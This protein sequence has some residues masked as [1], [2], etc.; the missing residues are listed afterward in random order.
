[1][2]KIIIIFKL[3]FIAI[4]VSVIISSLSYTALFLLKDKIYEVYRQKGI[5]FAFIAIAPLYVGSGLLIEL[6]YKTILPKVLLVE[7]NLDTSDTIFIYLSS[8]IIVIGTLMYAFFGRA[9][10]I[11]SK[12]KLILYLL[13]SILLTSILAYNQ[14]F[15]TLKITYVLEITAFS[16]MSSFIIKELHQNKR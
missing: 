13:A 7:I 10:D 4:M 12:E 2:E 6:L 8:L 16:L 11:L 9:S 15:S 5:H 3:H 1:M 14:S